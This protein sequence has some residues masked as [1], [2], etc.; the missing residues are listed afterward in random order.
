WIVMNK[1]VYVTKQ[2]LY[3]LRKL[4]QGDNVN[5]KA[6]MWDNFR[7]P[8]PLNRRVTWTNIDLHNNKA[9]NGQKESNCPRMKRETGYR[10][11]PK[12]T[13]PVTLDDLE[14]LDKELL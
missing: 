12:Y 10:V 13:E 8:L 1:P 7:P 4:M 9:Q 3:L 14:D 11:N 6:P 5:P 2:Q